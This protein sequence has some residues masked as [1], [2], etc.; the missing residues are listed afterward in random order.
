MN[1]PT[2]EQYFTEKLLSPVAEWQR[3]ATSNKAFYLGEKEFE[4]IPTITGHEPTVNYPRE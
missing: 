2:L 4:Y 3:E 1:S